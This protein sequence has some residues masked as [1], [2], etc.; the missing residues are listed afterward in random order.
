MISNRHIY[1]F[2]AFPRSRNI[3]RI[4][5]VKERKTPLHNDMM[6]SPPIQIQ[7][8]IKIIDNK[9]S[10]ATTHWFE[11]TFYNLTLIYS[12]L[13][14]FSTPPQS[15]DPYDVNIPNFPF[16]EE[17]NLKIIMISKHIEKRGFL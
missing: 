11:V 1:I 14:V 5:K 12:D 7:I 2:F 16:L 6:D 3:N 13:E 10:Y 17:G 15:P 8:K 9:K 4:F